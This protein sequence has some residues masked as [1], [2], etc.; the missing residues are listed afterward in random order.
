MDALIQDIRF[1]LRHM[2][3]HMSLTTVIAVSLALGIGANT[4]IFSLIRSLI[5]R[6]LPVQE[7]E[8]LVLFHWG[9]DAW[10]KGLSNSGAGG[11]TGTGWR[12]TSRSLPFPFFRQIANDTTLFSSVFAFA[13]LGMSRQNVTVAA[14]GSGE[15]VDGEMVSGGFFS[16][17]RRDGCGRTPHLAHR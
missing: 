12:A 4:A 15:R 6:E 13:P 9:A 1:T 16:G 14:G 10:P 5:L 17:P 7:A 3:K 8:R 2:A 11:P